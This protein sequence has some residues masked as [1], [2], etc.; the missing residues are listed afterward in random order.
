MAHTPITC[1]PQMSDITPYS[2]CITAC[3]FLNKTG[4]S[5]VKKQMEKVN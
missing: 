3:L 4:Y 1:N 2:A 5:V